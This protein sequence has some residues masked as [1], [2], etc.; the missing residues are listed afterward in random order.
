MDL[1][2]LLIPKGPAKTLKERLVKTQVRGSVLQILETM[3]EPGP[4][5][6]PILCGSGSIAIQLSTPAW[7]PAFAEMTT[8]MYLV[9]GVIGRYTKVL[10]GIGQQIK[11][12]VSV[13]HHF[14]WHVTL[15][16]SSDIR[17]GRGFVIGFYQ[18]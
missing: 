16:C 14:R 18:P 5:I 1:T 15:A 7:I 6:M 17:P 10:A 2:K 12:K 4:I 3:P 9:A 11:S 13:I 8:L